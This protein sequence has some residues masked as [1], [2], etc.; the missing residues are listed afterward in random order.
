MDL[1]SQKYREKKACH[2]SFD[3]LSIQSIKDYAHFYFTERYVI[4]DYNNKWLF[5][6]LIGTIK[7]F[8]VR[9]NAIVKCEVKCG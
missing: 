7:L 5:I 3:P 2:Y 9:E 6:I 8:H 1:F 4:T